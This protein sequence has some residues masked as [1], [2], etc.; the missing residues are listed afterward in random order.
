MGDLESRLR[1]VEEDIRDAADSEWR[2]GSADANPLLTQMRNQVAEA[3]QRL[4]RARA[5]GDK[6]RVKDAE[7]ALDSK[8]RFLQLAEQPQ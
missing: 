4:E 2:R 8:R 1:A 5:A 3:E 6:R 7:Q